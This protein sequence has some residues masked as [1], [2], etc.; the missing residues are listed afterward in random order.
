M[1]V[2]HYNIIYLACQ[3]SKTNKQNTN[4][5]TKIKYLLAF[6]I[7]FR[8]KVKL[9]EVGIL[10]LCRLRHDSYKLALNNA[11]IHFI[12]H[13]NRQNKIFIHCSDKND[14]RRYPLIANVYA[15]QRMSLVVIVHFFFNIV[16]QFVFYVKDRVGFDLSTE[17]RSP[18]Q[19]Q[20]AHAFYFLQK[21]Q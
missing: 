7:T 10:H 3:T 21:C 11:K 16:K 20:R 6:S 13:V 8:L 18:Q 9:K 12:N 4:N 5:I 19:A 2:C 17:N 1:S 14:Q 15:Y